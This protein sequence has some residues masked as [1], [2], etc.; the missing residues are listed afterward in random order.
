MLIDYWIIIDLII[1]FLSQS[2]ISISLYMKVSGEI[3]KNLYTLH[4]LQESLL[5]QERSIKGIL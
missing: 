5:L 3:T 2:Y 4:F 1:L